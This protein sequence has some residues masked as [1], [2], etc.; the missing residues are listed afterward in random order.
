MDVKKLLIGIVIIQSLVIIYL[1]ANQRKAKLEN[2][3]D[4]ETNFA[5]NMLVYLKANNPSYVTYLNFLMDNN[6]T[7]INLIKLQTYTQ[8]MALVQ[9]KS[10]SKDDILKS[11]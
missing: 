7:S 11:L 6:N 3:T 5:D 9:S 1:L 4:T 8:L 10:I 2:F